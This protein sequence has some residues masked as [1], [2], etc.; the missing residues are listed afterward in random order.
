MKEPPQ[1]GLD[2]CAPVTPENRFPIS[3]SVHP[4]RYA[5]GSVVQEQLSVTLLLAFPVGGE[6]EL[7]AAGMKGGVMKRRLWREGVGLAVGVAL[8]LVGCGG[9][10]G[11]ND[12]GGQQGS[13]YITLTGGSYVVGTAPQSSSSPDRPAITSVEGPQTLVRGE[14]ATYTVHYSDPSGNGSVRTLIVTVAGDSGYYALPMS[15]GNGT[16]TAEMHVLSTAADA[17]MKAA[18]V[19]FA[20]TDVDGNTS[21][22]NRQ[23]PDIVDPAQPAAFSVVG[24][25]DG[26]ANNTANNCG[27]QLH[28]ASPITW[29]FNANGTISGSDG[30]SGT[31]SLSG[32]T[33]TGLFMDNRIRFSLTADATGNS[34]TGT[35]SEVYTCSDSGTMV[36]DRVQ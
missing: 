13:R 24:V 6:Q 32:R 21:E 34:M 12:G 9:G 14:S 8:L 5:H 11:N 2:G 19:D 33:V 27:D 17:R 16:V 22:Y 26:I 4:N 29:T 20:V 28:G 7:Q 10:D 3:P 30:F 18:S 15:N 31:Y 23:S 36:L 1:G 25:W 35:W